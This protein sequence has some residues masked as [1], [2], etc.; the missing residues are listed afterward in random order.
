MDGHA[1]FNK[2]FRVVWSPVHK[3]WIA[4][5]ETSRASG[6]KVARTGVA[7]GLLT[8]LHVAQ[9]APN[10]GQ[11]VQGSG[12]ISQSGNTTTIHQ[13]TPTMSVNWQ[14]FN[15][16]SGEAVNF[17]QPSAAAI[18]V[19]RITGADPT[20][21]FGQLNAN[22][23]V[24]VINPNG[25]LFGTGSV[26]NVGGLVAATLDVSDTTLTSAARRFSGSSTASVVNQGQIHA[27]EGGYV[28][29]I[30]K[31]VRNDG[32]ISSTHGTTA[33]AGGSDVTLTF[34]NNQLLSLQVNQSTL[35]TLAENEGR[36][37]A[38]GGMVLH[39]RWCARL[40]CLPASSTTTA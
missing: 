10:G 36:I 8:A 30:G 31:A 37:S 28:A 29:F 17:V 1:S 39:D 32:A 20:R 18:A 3:T 27:A 13:S 12:S 14:S 24:Y 21:F 22:G 9:A 6:K 35:G 33:L 38:N 16:A 34:A 11:V 4:V 25:V 15:T 19:N 26:V 23:Q 40:R 2:V 7:L 5:S